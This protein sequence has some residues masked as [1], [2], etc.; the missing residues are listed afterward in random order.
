MWCLWVC[1]RER[2]RNQGKINRK[3]DEEI[4]KGRETE[5]DRCIERE[6]ERERERFLVK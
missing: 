5:K 4:K 2:E 1:G 6:T 3:R